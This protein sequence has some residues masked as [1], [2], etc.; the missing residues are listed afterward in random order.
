MLA[1]VLNHLI[2]IN[3]ST[4]RQLALVAGVCEQTIY[5]WKSGAAH[6]TEVAIRRWLNDHP[7]RVARTMILNDLT[8]HQASFV[9]PA[10]NPDP[11]VNKD[12]KVDLQDARECS[13]NAS[14]HTHQLLKKTHDNCNR[15]HNSLSALGWAEIFE[16]LEAARKNLDTAEHICTRE[17]STRRKAKTV[18]VAR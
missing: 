17:V 7:S 10:T 2:Q 5:N 8:Q 12:G 18:E 11:D 16:Q 3:E 14:G 6:P 4:V 9:Q 1:D 13:I 15:D